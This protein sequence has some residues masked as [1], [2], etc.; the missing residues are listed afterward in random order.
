MRFALVLLLASLA[1]GSDADHSARR[2][3]AL[4]ERG[5]ERYR[6][7]C[8]TRLSDGYAIT[9]RHVPKPNIGYFDVNPLPMVV[10][11]DSGA[12]WIAEEKFTS[13]AIRASTE[14]TPPART[15]PPDSAEAVRRAQ[16][17][18]G[19]GARIHCYIGLGEVGAFVQLLDR[20]SSAKGPTLHGVTIGV[21]GDYAR[22]VFTF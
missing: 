7:L 18:A 6:P 8:Q 21:D 1:C 2:A 3:Q 22:T 14:P 15:P 12:P 10:V 4:L 9:Y 20:A 11:P 13:D 16:A 19:P 5:G 17:I